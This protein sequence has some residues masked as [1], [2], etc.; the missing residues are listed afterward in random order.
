MD[1]SSEGSLGLHQTIIGTMNLNVIFCI[2]FRTL[3]FEI[4]LF[5]LQGY[6][7]EQLRSEELHNEKQ[8]KTATKKLPNRAYKG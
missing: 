3:F 1:E 6:C 5:S 2:A 4:F 7:S 8:K